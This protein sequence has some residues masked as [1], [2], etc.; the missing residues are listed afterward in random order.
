MISEFFIDIGFSLA[1]KFLSL[2]PKIEW[3]IET[4]AWEYAKD[5]I[6]MI[7]YL[8]PV[9]TITS[10]FSLIIAIAFLRVAIAVL[11]TIIGLIPFV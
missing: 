4:S 2:V 3:T 11:R 10:I 8:L 5:A 7:C 6:D 9:G 1:D